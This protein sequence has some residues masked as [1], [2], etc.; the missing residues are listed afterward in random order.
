MQL[1]VVESEKELAAGQLRLEQRKLDEEATRL[2]SDM[3]R[4][5]KSRAHASSLL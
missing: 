4:R 2:A 1:R 3:V 5:C